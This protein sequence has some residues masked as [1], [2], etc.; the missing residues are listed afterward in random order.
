L[1]LD[2]TGVVDEVPALGDEM[3]ISRVM[4]GLGNQ[5]FIYATA[6][7]LA[8]ANDSVLVLDVRSGYR[9][10]AYGRLPEL[11]SFD[12]RA[13]TAGPLK[14]L[15]FPGARAIRWGLRRVGRAGCAVGYIRE[16]DHRCFDP[17][18]LG[19][20]PSLV[21]FMEGY[22]QSPRY[23]EDIAPLLRRELR[24][25]APHD[26]ENI[27]WSE[28]IRSKRSAVAV[29]ARRLYN[30]SHSSPSNIRSVGPAYY[31]EAMRL[32]SSAV[33]DAH[34]FCFADQQ[35]WFAQNLQPG[36]P[37]THVSH[38]SYQG[39]RAYEDLWLMSQCRHF[40]VA[41][42]T[43][44]WWAAWLGASSGSIVIAPDHS[45]WDNRD[46]LPPQWR[47]LPGTRVS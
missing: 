24:I 18:L 5:L 7:R 8:I 43:F 45:H 17:E 46:I 30:S 13:E 4:G 29:H 10:D 6:R 27:A 26:P 39:A 16:R 41:N 11:H 28:R 32:I 31:A 19:I 3:I 35:D 12:V 34:F 33:P 23:F 42:S 38:N 22:W 9:R 21:T 1:D 36:V 15:D 44:S 20:R 2:A 25:L 47:L 14:S 37:V 40:I